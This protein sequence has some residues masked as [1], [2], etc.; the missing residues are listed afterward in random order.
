M[1]CLQI[2]QSSS[3]GLDEHPDDAG[4]SRSA[5]MAGVLGDADQRGITPIF[6]TNMTPYGE[7]QLDTNR[8]L[9]LGDTSPEAASA[10]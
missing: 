4:H 9:A 10:S 8:R 6:H 3:L 2:L 1:I 7:I 5:G